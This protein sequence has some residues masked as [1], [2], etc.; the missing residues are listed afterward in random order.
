[1]AEPSWEL[2]LG[3]PD[4]LEDPLTGLANH[5]A[6]QEQLQ[7]ELCAAVASGAV[8]SLALIDVD[9]LGAV[10]GSAGYDAGDRILK[11]VAH[12]LLR[13]RRPGD[14]VARVGGDEFAV[15][16]RGASAQ[17]AGEWLETVQRRMGVSLATSAGICDSNRAASADALRQH[18]QDALR[19]ARRSGGG[20]A[21][22]F[23]PRMAELVPAIA[24]ALRGLRALARVI[25]AKDPAT[26][27]HSTRVTTLAAALARRLGWPLERI[28]LLR[29]AALVHDVGKV[30]VPDA[31]LFSTRRL[32]RT[33]YEMV[34]R[35]AELGAEICAGLLL[36]E[37][38]EWIRHHHER[39]DGSGYPDGL[40]GERISDGSAILAVADAFDV[41]TTQRPYSAAKSFAEALREC[42]RLTD[43]QFLAGPVEALQEL[44]EETQ[45]DAASESPAATVPAPAP[46]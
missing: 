4:V 8:I 39:P 5:R 34:K 15:L 36:P 25:D 21:H 1:M 32:S 22:I 17:R 23:E 44:Y 12:A 46:R 14:V 6:F 28:D 35:H 31:V 33:Q 43:E 40:G 13:A 45:S 3:A 26:R 27:A 19:W 7:A 30:G 11:G 29:E 41:M 20:S 10:N 2:R 38:V 18:A 16:L 9:H 37:Q 24:P 42:E